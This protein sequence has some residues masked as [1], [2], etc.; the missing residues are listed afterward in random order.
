MK[1]IC[2]NDGTVFGE[3]D[4]QSTLSDIQSKCPA[5]FRTPHGK[6]E[7]YTIYRGQLI[8]RNTVK[9]ASCKPSRMTSVYLFFVSG[10]MKSD[11]FCISSGSNI[12]TIGQAEQ[13]IDRV[14]DGGKY[15]YG[16]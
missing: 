14:L 10:E 9:F 3:V 16:I 6:R 15:F 8:V 1:T 4:E 13:L 12:H 5:F 11:T 7:T 2:S